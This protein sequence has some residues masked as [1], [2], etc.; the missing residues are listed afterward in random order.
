MTLANLVGKG[1]E[2][3][4][5]DADEVARY[6]EKIGRK[7]EDSKRTDNYL[8]TR[9]DIAFEALLQIAI[10]AL[11]VNGYRTTSAAGHQQVAIQLLPK[12]IG[13]ETGSVRLLDEYR[14]KRSLGLYQADFEPSEKEVKA[15]IEAVERLRAGL[16]AWIKKNHP[17]L[18]N[19]KGVRPH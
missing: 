10:C 11:R 14:K 18:L 4:E 13:I 9:F 12:S 2:K 3:A 6:L 19:K 17:E 7:L 15:V 8:D 5:T 1:L 16:V